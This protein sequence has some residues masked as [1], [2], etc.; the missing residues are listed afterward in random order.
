MV[1]SS[2]LNFND[3]MCFVAYIEKVDLGFFSQT[4]LV[5]F[6]LHFKGFSNRFYRF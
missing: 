6:P 4:G 1:K 3:V 2:D 5:L